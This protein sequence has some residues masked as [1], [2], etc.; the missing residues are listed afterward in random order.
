M[1]I[2]S[3]FFFVMVGV[4]L[5]IYWYMPARHQWKLLLADSL[6]FYFANATWY[7]F[8]YVA[9]SVVSVYGATRYFA[10]QNDAKSKKRVLVLTILLN[11]GI[12]AVLKY[13]NFAIHTF[14]FLGG[15]ILHIQGI[16]DVSWLAPL[17]ISFYMLQLLSYLLDCYWGVAEPF[18]NVLHAALYTIYFPLMTS[19][20]I[21]RFDDLGRQLF[22]EHRFDYDR[23]RAGLIRIAWGL[24]KKLAISNRAAVIV[25]GMWAAPETSRGIC[26]WIAVAVF[27]VQLYTDFSGVMDIALGVSSCFG[28]TLPENFRSP[29]F[30]RSVQEFW[31]RWH[32]TLGTWL[33]DY[34]MNPVLRSKPLQKLGA[35][36]RKKYGRKTG[37]R[38]PT[39]LAMLVL[40]LA[41]GLWH[42]GSWR[43][44]V[45]MGCWFWLVI[46]SGQLLEPVFDQMKSGLHIQEESWW[47]HA[48][49]SLRTIGLWMVSLLFFRSESLPDSLTRL[50]AS[51]HVQLNLGFLH[52]IL[53]AVDFGDLG[54]IGGF[55]LMLLCFVVVLVKD[56]LEYRGIN[57]QEKL[58]AM[59]WPYRWAAYYAI[60]L[61]VFF[62]LNIAGQESLY[63]QF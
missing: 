23:V 30:S 48:F 36:C 12:L 6:I 29:F 19:G 49:Q 10:R 54:G 33:R 50:A 7:T 21:C 61:V 26:V 20:P 14:N 56:Y 37:K 17:A 27:V 11:A 63:A 41:T 15:R 32:I 60:V 22:E 43:F 25:D 38:I 34:I 39:Y 53:V 13:T 35:V 4:S 52:D 40:W 9:V 46:V 24:F 44:I 1:E 5:L 58:A 55:S 2:T 18:D 45:G 62:S 42:E 51:F 57:V 59:K 31:R 3:F 16:S 47:W 28:I 8:G